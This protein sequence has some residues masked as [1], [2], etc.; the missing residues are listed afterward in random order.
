[1]TSLNFRS[2]VNADGTVSSSDIGG[3]KSMAGTT[4][5]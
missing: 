1:V 5:Q 4:L 3:V 2:D